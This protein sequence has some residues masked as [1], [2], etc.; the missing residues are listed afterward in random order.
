MDR[1]LTGRL[2]RWGGLAAL[3]GPALVLVGSVLGTV[4]YTGQD[5][6]EI[7]G[8]TGYFAATGLGFLGGMTLVFGM[9]SLYRSQSEEAGGWGVAGFV[10]A[11]I[12]TIL[13]TASLWA[14]AMVVPSVN[15][16]AP[17]FLELLSN[18]EVTG[19]LGV[20]MFLPF[21]FEVLGF[22][23][24]G[25]ATYRARVFSRA[26]GIALIV[27]ALLQAVPHGIAIVPLLLTLAWM[28]YRV[29]ARQIV[30]RRETRQ[31]AEPQRTLETAG[32]R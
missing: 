23:L 9:I 22:L 17:E 21:A 6:P 10:G 29:F 3:V 14:Q 11:M 30:P 7:A 13:L 26:T 25:I 5:L 28:G 20:A 18:G 1:N 24:F 4:L 8:E 32:Q 16:H 27:S 12:G 2:L 15:A 31:L 19:P